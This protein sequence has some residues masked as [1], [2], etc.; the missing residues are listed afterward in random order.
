M[1]HLYEVDRNDVE[2]IMD[3]FLNVRKE[4]VAAFGDYRTRLQILEIYDAMER[5]KGTA[6]PYETPIDPPPADP[7]TTHSEETRPDWAG[8]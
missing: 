2:Y 7:R 3:S 8:A 4:D 6:K 1:F 5:A